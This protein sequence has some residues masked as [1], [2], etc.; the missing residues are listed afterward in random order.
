MHF[1]TDG[2]I[3]RKK[4][5]SFMAAARQFACPFFLVLTGKRAPKAL[6][7]V[8]VKRRM[9]VGDR[10]TLI[11]ACDSDVRRTNAETIIRISNNNRHE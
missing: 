6:V 3:R 9:Q 2:A 8:V 7:S 10:E 4:R 1:E 5:R 11:P